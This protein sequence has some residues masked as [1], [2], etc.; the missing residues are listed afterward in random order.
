[1][2]LN[3]RQAGVPQQGADSFS[4][5]LLAVV[6]LPFPAEEADPAATAFWAVM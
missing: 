6:Y 3:T 4:P 1:M 2:M 5:V